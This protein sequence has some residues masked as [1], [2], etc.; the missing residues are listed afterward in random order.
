MTLRAR[1]ARHV[2]DVDPAVVRALSKEFATREKG[3][4][5]RLAENVDLLADRFWYQ[6]EQLTR[7]NQTWPV[8][9][10]LLWGTTCC[11][12]QPTS[13]GNFGLILTQNWRQFAPLRL[14]VQTGSR[15]TSV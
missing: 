11:W 15:S 9:L 3:V 12:R 8:E 2:F 10:E 14:D 1:S 5:A 4:I 6:Y 13:N 7:G